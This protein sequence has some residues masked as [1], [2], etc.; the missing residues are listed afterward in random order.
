M[1]RDTSNVVNSTCINIIDDDTLHAFVSG[2]KYTYELISNKYYL[3]ESRN[4]HAPSGYTCYTTAQIQTLPS[5]F[6]Y[7]DPFLNTMAIATVI[8]IFYVSFRVILY[9]FYRRKA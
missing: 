6:D 4:G 3:S 7:V 8:A 2:T 1:K 9:P 5:N